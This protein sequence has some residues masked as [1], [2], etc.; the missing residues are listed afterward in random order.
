VF[1]QDLG[2]SGEGLSGAELVCGQAQGA[3][4]LLTAEIA[5]CRTDLFYGLGRFG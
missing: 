4:V 2:G 5:F 1:A 3:V